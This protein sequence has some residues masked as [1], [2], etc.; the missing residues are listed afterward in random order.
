MITKR[1]YSIYLLITYKNL[2]LTSHGKFKSYSVKSK[3][4]ILNRFAT[5][6]RRTSLNTILNFE[7]LH[8]ILIFL[9]IIILL[10]R[11]TEIHRC[12][13][14]K[15]HPILIKTF[16]H[17]SDFHPRFHQI[18][19]FT[20]WPKQS[21]KFFTFIKMQLDVECVIKLRCW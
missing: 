19:D 12:I 13:Q 18:Y 20:I 7:H 15:F 21:S 5:K 10:S 17:N 8:H 2:I 9:M 11:N 6:R 4:S 3:I 14:K 1:L 16:F